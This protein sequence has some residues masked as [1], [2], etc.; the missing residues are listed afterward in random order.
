M[1]V[2]CLSFLPCIHYSFW[3]AFY[4][5]SR[6]SSTQAAQVLKENVGLNRT[7]TK[8]VTAVLPHTVIKL[9]STLRMIITPG[10]KYQ[11][12]RRS[13]KQG[14]KRWDLLSIFK[15]KFW[16]FSGDK[17][18]KWQTLTWTGESWARNPE[19]QAL[20]PPSFS[21]PL[22]FF[23][24]SHMRGICWQMRPAPA[25]RKKQPSSECYTKLPIFLFFCII[26]CLEVRRLPRFARCGE[27][28]SPESHKITN[29][30]RHITFLSGKWLWQSSA[31]RG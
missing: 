18:G 17:E 11:S 12:N 19:L 21:M 13:C 25:E 31:G 23:R 9:N 26:F 29:V 2:Y 14:F 28:E 5:R 22:F 20:Y 6:R 16:H 1:F 24:T 15:A 7:F 8:F 27:T 3:L 10:C 4:W 30:K